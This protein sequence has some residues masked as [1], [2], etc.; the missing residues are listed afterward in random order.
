MVRQDSFFRQCKIEL[1]P[2]IHDLT[3]CIQQDVPS[4]RL[5]LTDHGL[6]IMLR[7]CWIN[8]LLLTGMLPILHPQKRIQSTT[9]LWKFKKYSPIRFGFIYLSIYFCI[10]NNLFKKSLQSG[11]SAFVCKHHC[12]FACPK[13]SNVW[14]IHIHGMDIGD[15]TLSWKDICRI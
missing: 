8:V 14:Q 10:S 15:N 11:L 2:Q 3:R 4:V 9:D 1:N 12:Y 7:I 13:D 6:E 5:I